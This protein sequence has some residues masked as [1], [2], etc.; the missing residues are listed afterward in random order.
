MWQIV[1]E[2]NED[3]KGFGSNGKTGI[4]E[5]IWIKFSNAYPSFLVWRKIINLDILT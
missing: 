5:M 1:G 3:E 4:K 2:T